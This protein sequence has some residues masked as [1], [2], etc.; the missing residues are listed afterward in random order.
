M[1]TPVPS[2]CS[3]LPCSLPWTSDSPTAVPYPLHP[4]SCFSLIGFYFPGRAKNL[5]I[6]GII[7]NP[8]K[9]LFSSMSNKEQGSVPLLGTIL[10]HGWSEV[11]QLGWHLPLLC[12]LLLEVPAP[13]LPS[14][15]ENPC[16]RASIWV[17]GHSRSSC[18]PYGV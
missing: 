18:V 4:A 16:S 5:P 12:R 6:S 13:R 1:K 11:T 7:G 14:K 9:D 17:V 10:S 2:R 15:V 3:S 8:G